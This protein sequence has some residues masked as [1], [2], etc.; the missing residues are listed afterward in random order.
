MN[1]GGQVGDETITTKED[2]R[3]KKPYKQPILRVYGTMQEL[4][5]TSSTFGGIGDV[6]GPA[7]DTKTH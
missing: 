5:R 1:I 4:T 3:L 6:R 7:H 2:S